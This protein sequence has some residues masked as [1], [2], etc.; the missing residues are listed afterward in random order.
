MLKLIDAITARMKQ[1]GARMRQ[2]ED[3]HCVVNTLNVIRRRDPRNL[4]INSSS[5]PPIKF[6]HGKLNEAGQM[7]LA[8]VL[9]DYLRKKSS[10]PEGSRV[11]YGVYLEKAKEVV[12]QLSLKDL[13]KFGLL[14]WPD[15][16][17]CFIPENS[18]PPMLFLE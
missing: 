2:L 12:G 8:H 10:G 5:M 6:E 11:S 4:S 15:S 14:S 18:L 9:A 1:L 16:K 17:G 3:E 13:K 7:V